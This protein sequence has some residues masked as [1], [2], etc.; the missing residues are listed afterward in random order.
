M[1]R[2]Y[3]KPDFRGKTAGRRLAQ[4][5]I[6]AGIMIGYEVMRLDTLSS[7]ESANTLYPS[8][9]FRQIKPYR[10]NP[11]EGAIYMELNLT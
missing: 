2:L 7:M 11:I 10:H 9:G 6:K 8:L 4:A 5:A 3:V 1:K